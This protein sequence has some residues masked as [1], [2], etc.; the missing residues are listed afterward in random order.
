M[1]EGYLMPSRKRLARLTREAIAFRSRNQ[2]P[3]WR[4]GGHLLTVLNTYEY[5]PSYQL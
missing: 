1:I 3:S 5:L 2:V 4:E